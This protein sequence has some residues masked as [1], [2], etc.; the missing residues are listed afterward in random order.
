MLYNGYDDI[1]P[2]SYV[3][4]KRPVCLPGQR[5]ERR[6]G[7]EFGLAVPVEDNLKGDVG[8]D[9]HVFCWKPA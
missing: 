1:E 7:G 3:K 6:G 4:P 5:T 9:F 8:C 2:S